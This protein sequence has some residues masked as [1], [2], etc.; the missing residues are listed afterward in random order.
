M[1]FWEN[2]D[3]VIKWR[4]LELTY[5]EGFAIA[6]DVL[7][8]SWTPVQIN[9]A[10]IVEVLQFLAPFKETLG[11]GTQDVLHHTE[12]LEVAVRL[13]HGNSGE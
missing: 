2:R 5:S 9:Q 13:E 10:R 12:M 8:F 7:P 4:D 3:W 6:D 1:L 11:D